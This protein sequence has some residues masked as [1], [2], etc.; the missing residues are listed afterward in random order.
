[1]ALVCRMKLLLIYL[2]LYSYHEQS[3]PFDRMVDQIA[4][5]V[6][7]GGGMGLGVP[8][9]ESSVLYAVLP[10]QPLN[11]RRIEVRIGY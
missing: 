3:M 1:M 10:L 11:F 7:R 5:R 9:G 2:F 8:I 4:R 6:P